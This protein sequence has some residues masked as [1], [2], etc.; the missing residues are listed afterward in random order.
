MAPPKPYTLNLVYPGKSVSQGPVAEASAPPPVGGPLLQS[1]VVSL[2]VKSRGS[3]FR[4]QGF[5]LSGLV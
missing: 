3:G 4:V 2:G 5:E 1:E